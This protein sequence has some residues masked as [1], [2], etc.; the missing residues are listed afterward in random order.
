[1]K[2]GINV[3]NFGEDFTPR[4]LAEL[5]HEAEESGWDG[6]F[7]WDH[8]QSGRPR[9]D[10]GVA[11]PMVDP[12]IALAAIAMRTERIR[13]GPMV[14]PLPR[15]R[16]W[17]LARE[18]VTL[19]HL[20]NGRLTLGVGLGSPPGT[21]YEQFGESGEAAVRAEM[22]D[23]GLDVLIGLWSGEPLTYEGQHY[24]VKGATFQPRPVQQPRIP[25][26]VA[27]MWPNKPPLRRAARYEGA[28]PLASDPMRS[29]K[30]DDVQ[31]IV[32]YVSGHRESHKP[33]DL[34]LAGTTSKDDPGETLERLSALANAGATWWQET[35][36]PWLGSLEDMRQ[37]VHKGPLGV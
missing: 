34:V 37:L 7:I 12:W 18:T 19:D 32:Q 8:I 30:P 20:S 24:Q 25:I 10:A 11:S 13:I 17:K 16:P 2:Y 15:R 22:L 26:W 23:E 6:F 21:E 1:M 9:V 4:V 33:F 27:G 28:F 14:T 35:L 31:A 3:T 5:A 36:A 29:L